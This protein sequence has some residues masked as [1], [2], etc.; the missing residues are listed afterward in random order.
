MRRR[1][2]IESK[3]L[4]VRDIMR[5]GVSTLGRNEKLSFVEELMKLRI[6]RYGDHGHT[7]HAP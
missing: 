3:Q 4:N 1:V 6:D 2:N 7:Y 5:N